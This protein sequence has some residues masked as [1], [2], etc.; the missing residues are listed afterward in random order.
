V[1]SGSVGLVVLADV[2][3]AGRVLAWFTADVLVP[4]VCELPPAVSA[5]IR[6]T[7]T[8]AMISPASRIRPRRR[9][10]RAA[11]ARRSEICRRGTGG[12]RRI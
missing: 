5:M 1:V 4:V 12:I 3:V 11:A 8:S 2:E 10:R 7:N 6:T 9:R